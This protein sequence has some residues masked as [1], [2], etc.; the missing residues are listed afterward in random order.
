MI[1]T[2]YENLVRYTGGEMRLLASW[3]DIFYVPGV[4][5]SKFIAMANLAARNNLYLDVAVGTILV[6]ISNNPD[7]WQVISGY[8]DWSKQRNQPWL[9]FKGIEMISLLS[10]D[11]FHPTKWGSILIKKNY[12][13]AKFYCNVVL[14]VLHS[15]HGRF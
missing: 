3:G 10:A 9:H 8:T 14:P 11:F 13:M 6:A 1:Q 5:Q 2:C 4:L 12:E 7:D 15:Q